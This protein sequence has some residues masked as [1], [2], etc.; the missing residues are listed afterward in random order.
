M[1]SQEPMCSLVPE[2]MGQLT[3][4]NVVEGQYVNKGQVLATI[5]SETLEKNIEEVKNQ[6]SLRPPF[7]KKRPL[8]EAKYWYRNRLFAGQE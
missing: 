4:V 2:T 5:D 7:R 1:C 6:W 8:V 3:A